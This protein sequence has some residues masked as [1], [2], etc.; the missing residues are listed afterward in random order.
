MT[1]HFKKSRTFREAMCEIND[2]IRTLNDYKGAIE[3]IGL[4]IL[5][6]LASIMLLRCK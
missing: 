6:I 2:W 4:L 5:V 1:N 3:L